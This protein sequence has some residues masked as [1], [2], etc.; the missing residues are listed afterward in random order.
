MPNSPVLTENEI[1]KLLMDM[2]SEMAKLS[3][4]QQNIKT[5]IGELKDIRSKDAEKIN[6]MEKALGELCVD[7]T[8]IKKDMQRKKDEKIET[9]NNFFKWLGAA[10]AVVT[11]FA[12]LTYELG[13]NKPQPNSSNT[14]QT[15][16][17]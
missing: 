16:L 4:T 17:K 7:I 11:L 6:T 9:R 2:N 14:I 13:L 8:I 1:M 15:Q 3:T 10:L 5:D 12:S